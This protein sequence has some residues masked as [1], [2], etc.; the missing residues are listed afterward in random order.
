MRASY[1]SQQQIANN[2]RSVSQINIKTESLSTLL[3]ILKIVHFFLV[4]ILMNNDTIIEINNQMHYIV[5]QGQ[6]SKVANVKSAFRKR[7]LEKLG[8][9]FMQFEVDTFV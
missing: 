8:Y 5:D 7:I 6:Q 2:L 4:D 9:K 3:F 1:T